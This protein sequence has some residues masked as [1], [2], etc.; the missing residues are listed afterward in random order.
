[1]EAPYAHSW[2]K[3]LIYTGD[4]SAERPEFVERVLQAMLDAVV[5]L[6]PRTNH[7]MNLVRLADRGVYVAACGRRFPGVP[8]PTVSEDVQQIA[9]DAVD[10]CVRAGKTR[11]ALLATTLTGSG[12][13]PSTHELVR[14]LQKACAAHPAGLPEPAVCASPMMLEGHEIALRQFLSANDADAY[15]CLLHDYMTPLAALAREGFWP[16]PRQKAVVDVF[17]HGGTP[18]PT[19]FGGLHVVRGH[20]AHKDEG[21]ALAQLLQS[22]WTEGV[23]A[24]PLDYPVRFEELAASSSSYHS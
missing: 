3:E 13:D 9:R 21:A 14:A 17:G 4:G 2:R 11:L 23:E 6:R 5:W 12:A 15:I 22:M 8:Y 7:Q 20:V 1:M 18:M 10:W 24:P 19:D 16:E